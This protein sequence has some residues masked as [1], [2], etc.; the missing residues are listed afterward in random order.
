MFL[1][2]T[3]SKCL[4]KSLVDVC[5]CVCVCVR[6]RERER[7]RERSGEYGEYEKVSHL[8]SDVFIGHPGNMWLTIVMKQNY[9]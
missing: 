9:D 5:V 7:E 3:V 1:H 2:K 6:E 8:K 4:K